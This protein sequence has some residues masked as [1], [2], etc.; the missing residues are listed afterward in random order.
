MPML[1]FGVADTNA[2][3]WWFMLLNICIP[4]ANRLLSMWAMMGIIMVPVL[5]YRMHITRPKINAPMKSACR[6]PKISDDASIAFFKPHLKVNLCSITP[7]K[8]NS[9]TIGAAIT[10]VKKSRKFM[11]GASGVSWGV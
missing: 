4:Y 11:K 6:T 5:M 3:F 1:G 10:P 9:S 8:S 2:L 7:L